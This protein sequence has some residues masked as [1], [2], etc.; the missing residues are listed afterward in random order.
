MSKSNSRPLYCIYLPND[1]AKWFTTCFSSFDRAVWYAKISGL[2][3]DDF[4]IRE[5]DYYTKLEQSVDENAV[6]V[7]N[8]IP[9]SFQEATKD[10]NT[11][12]VKSVVNEV[13]A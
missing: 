10:A 5:R 1:S 8:N 2:N 12:E 9:A 11:E 3:E 4:D 6:S 7:E 13:A